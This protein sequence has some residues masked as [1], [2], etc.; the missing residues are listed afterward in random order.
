MPEPV[1]PALE[2]VPLARW[3]GTEWV[4]LITDPPAPITA[5]QLAA[6]LAQGGPWVTIAW[7]REPL[8]EPHGNHRALERALHAEE[9]RSARYVAAW[10]R[11]RRNT[12]A[13]ARRARARQASARPDTDRSTGAATS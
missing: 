13:R 2:P 6:L 12:R 7:P 10:R 4:P 1:G 5:E 8:Y 11:I 9:A 3:D